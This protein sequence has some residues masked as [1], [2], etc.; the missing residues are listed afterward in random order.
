LNRNKV[1]E[2]ESAN[3]PPTVQTMKSLFANSY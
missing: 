3:F 1:F 2:V